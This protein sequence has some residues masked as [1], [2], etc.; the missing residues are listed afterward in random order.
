MKAQRAAQAG[1]P[2]LVGPLDAPGACHGIGVARGRAAHAAALAVWGRSADLLLA[3]DAAQRARVGARDSGAVSVGTCVPAVPGGLL[4]RA[5]RR[6]ASEREPLSGHPGGEPWG[7]PCSVQQGGGWGH[8]DAVARSRRSPVGPEHEHSPAKAAAAAAWAMFAPLQAHAQGCWSPA[9]PQPLFPAASAPQCAGGMPRERVWGLRGEYGYDAAASPDAQPVGT[10]GVGGARHAV[11][12]WA[13]TE[14]PIARAP[15]QARSRRSGFAAAALERSFGAGDVAAGT[16]SRRSAQAGGRAAQLA[17]GG[18]CVGAPTSA[19]AA[20]SVCMGGGEAR[21]SSV[22]GSIDAAATPA[23]PSSVLP[24]GA[25]A[26][27][28]SSAR[29]EGGPVEARAGQPERGRRPGRPDE[30]AA[31]AESPGV[32]AA[33]RRGD[34]RRLPSDPFGGDAAAA[35]APPGPAR[36]GADSAGP[37]QAAAD[38]SSGATAVLEPAGAGAAASRIAGSS[39][40]PEVTVQPAHARTGAAAATAGCSGSEPGATAWPR[41]AGAGAAAALAAGAAPAA[42]AAGAALAGL[43]VAARCEAWAAHA[44]RHAEAGAVPR[45]GG[46]AWAARAPAGA[47]ACALRADAVLPRAPIPPMIQVPTVAAACTAIVVA[48]CLPRRH[49]SLSVCLLA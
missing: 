14:R 30:G 20:P 26:W 19:P 15:E 3:Q 36:S 16:A 41:P 25:L 39:P 29:S 42:G 11:A 28:P 13:L 32:A 2:V 31:I 45:E 7:V 5:P 47:S 24:L 6:G 23:R 12:M 17:Q 46:G 43:S 44:A 48:Q 34:L 27:A 4:S 9:A 8:R 21:S 35:A 33:A 18:R 22:C 40:E 38:R 37:A 10:P 1:T 49:R